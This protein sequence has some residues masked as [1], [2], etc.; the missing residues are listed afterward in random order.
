MRPDPLYGS[1]THCEL[2]V[3]IVDDTNQV[4]NSWPHVKSC[5][6]LKNATLVDRALG[7]TR[8]LLYQS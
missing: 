4:G 6:H 2:N 7:L 8:L 1:A 5:L 3:G